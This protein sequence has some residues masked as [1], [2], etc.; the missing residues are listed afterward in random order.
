MRIL[1]AHKFFRVVGGAEVFFFETGRLL[2]EA[3][4][5][6]AFLSTEHPDNR[7][8]PFSQYFIRSHD[9]VGGGLYGRARTRHSDVLAL[10]QTRD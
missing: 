6:V 7:E 5:Q 8:S 10:G 1:L 3:G 4:H 9:Y 2:E